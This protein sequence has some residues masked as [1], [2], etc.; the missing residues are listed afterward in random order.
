MA[1]SNYTPSPRPKNFGQPVQETQMGENNS[2][3]GPNTPVPDSVARKFNWGAFLLSWIWGL[4]N[5][6]YITLLVF[7][8]G[9]IPFIGIVLIFGMQIWFGIKGNTWA[10]QN[11]RFQSIEHFHENQR[12]WAIAGVTIGGI[13]WFLGIIGVIM[14][15]TVSTFVSNAEYTQQKTM[16]SKVVAAAQHVA[17][18]N[19]TKNIKCDLTSNGLAACFANQ[20]ISAKVNGSTVKAADLTIWNFKGDGKCLNDGDC[21]VTIS[22]KGVDLI[23]MP[24]IIN[25]RGYIYPK[26]E[27]IRENVDIDMSQ[28]D[29]DYEKQMENYDEQMAKI[30]KDYEEQMKKID[31]MLE[32]IKETK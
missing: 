21:S 28:Y 25:E 19:E 7:L 24:L 16:A 1:F 14:A 5:K 23:T 20:M 13:L 6:T 32:E 22:N 9:F 31:A 11:K 2:G 17:I 10:W 30:Q 15:L 27:D 26:A 29:K 12:N 3:Q 4:G 18:M 8:V